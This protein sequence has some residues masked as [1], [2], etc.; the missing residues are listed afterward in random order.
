MEI[1]YYVL[2]LT[3]KLATVAFGLSIHNF[4]PVQLFLQI[5]RL[6]NLGILNKTTKYHRFG[7]SYPATGSLPAASPP[8]F[9]KAMNLKVGFF[10]PGTDRS[11]FLSVN[12]CMYKKI[13]DYATLLATSTC[14]KDNLRQ[15][16]GTPLSF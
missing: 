5:K 3:S 16:C 14:K 4:V 7:R 2:C 9:W 10:T 6:K 12:L 1:H 15:I 13:T 8:D 11:E